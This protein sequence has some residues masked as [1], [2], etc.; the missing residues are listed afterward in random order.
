MSVKCN[1]IRDTNFRDTL[2]TTSLK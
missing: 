1:R 2:R